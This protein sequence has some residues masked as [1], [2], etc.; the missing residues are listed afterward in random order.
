MKFYL[1]LILIF[2]S[3]SVFG[4]TVNFSLDGSGQYIQPE[5]YESEE[6]E[7]TA[8]STRF[9]VD[10]LWENTTYKRKYTTIQEYNPKVGINVTGNIHIKITDKLNFKSGLGL[11]YLLF[12]SYPTASFDIENQEIISIDTVIV[13]ESPGSPGSSGPLGVNP[14]D[15]F[16]DFQIIDFSSIK[17]G[18]TN[19][20]L[21]LRIPLEVEYV[22][23][24]EKFFIGVGGYLQTPL[25]SSVSREYV[26]TKMEEINGETVCHN[27]KVVEKDKTGS[28]FSDL[29][30]G[31]GG[32]FTYMFSKQLGVRF[33]VSKDLNSIFI[34][35]ES[36]NIPTF[37]EFKPLKF[38]LGIRYRFGSSYIMTK[39]QM[40]K[41]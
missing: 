24:N 29:Q 21:S 9:L 35:P 25:Y 27:E 20:L 19:Q 22:F 12:D 37:D 40:E 34:K 31:I 18:K 3:I 17:N 2:V 38:S 11:N 39:D 41:M 8:R 23:L 26:T 6:R 5:N 33:G 16:I 1:G 10:S 32:N 30:M 15:T 36:T 7:I 4:Q 14:C 13:S 28:A